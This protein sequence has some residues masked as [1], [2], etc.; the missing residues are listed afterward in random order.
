MVGWAVTA[1]VETVTECYPT[2]ID[3]FVEL[4]RRVRESPKPAIVVFQEVG[5]YP[6]YAAHCGEVMSTVLKRLGVVGLV[7]DC[8]VRDI[9]EVRAVGFYYFARGAVVSH[10]NFTS[11]GLG[12]PSRFTACRCRRA[13]SF[14]AM[15]TVCCR[16]RAAARRPS[17]T[18]WRESAR[19]SA[20]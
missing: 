2:S 11:S 10:A 8:T 20:V 16:C 17:R 14:T 3:L 9:P 19:A 6:S 7:S 13:I 1:Q 4:Y 15:K 5:G 12:C 18:R